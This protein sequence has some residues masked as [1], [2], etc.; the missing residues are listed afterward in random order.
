MLFPLRKLSTD[1]DNPRDLCY[2][3]IYTMALLMMIQRSIAKLK[4]LESLQSLAN[5]IKEQGIINPIIVYKHG[6]K[7]RLIA[8]ERRTFASVLAKKSISKLRFWMENQMKLKL[9]CYNG[10][11]ILNVQIYL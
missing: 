9:D 3:Q 5:S 6:E 11:K 4:E 8:G 10:L 1:L 7:Y 2:I